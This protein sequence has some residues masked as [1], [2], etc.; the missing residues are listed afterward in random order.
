MSTG[1][2]LQSP[3]SR[4]RTRCGLCF[5]FP[6]NLAASG[7]EFARH[8]RSRSEGNSPTNRISTIAGIHQGGDVMLWRGRLTFQQEILR[9]GKQCLPV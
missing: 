1:D 5:R 3:P 6:L 4:S 2:A 9:F 8:I 7:S